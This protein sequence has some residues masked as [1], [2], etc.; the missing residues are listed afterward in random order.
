MQPDLGFA[1]F[2]ETLAQVDDWVVEQATAPGTLLQLALVAGALVV[3]LALAPVLRRRIGG[4]AEQR[5]SAA[6]PA[7]PRLFALLRE[8]VLPALWVAFVW[9]AVVAVRDGGWPVE[10]VSGALSLL[11]A[12]IVIRVA[13]LAIRS[14]PLARMLAVLVWG[15][16]ALEIVDLLDPAAAMLDNLGFSLGTVRVSALGIVKAVGVLAVLLWLAA[17]AARL[18]E[19]LV[20]RVDGLTPAVRVLLSRAAKVGMVALAVLMALSALGVDLTAF[21]F[22]TGAIG[23]GIGLGLQRIVANV[24]AGVIILLDRSI[25]PGDVI[26]I[27]ETYGWIESVSARYTAVRTRDG[28]EHLIPNEELITQ[29]VEN[30]SHTDQLLRLR[31]P[32]GISYKSD[33]R[34]A[35]AIC[36]EAARVSPRVLDEPPPVCLLRGFGDSSVKLEL[37]MWIADPQDGQA[38]VTSEVLLK[39]WDEFHGQG[40]EIPFPQRDLH[41][42]T[43]AVLSVDIAG[44]QA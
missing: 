15:V 9:L 17:L 36:L 10:I 16:V 20:Q 44:R 4:P 2:G 21:A 40:I 22:L 26:A 25:K 30:W 39:I 37:R 19:Q 13:A 38:N 23:I 7:A 12:W 31:V 41:L 14:R 27:G 6:W 35:M 5:L 11:V 33:L 18:V 29:R 3:A 34:R 32:V 1:D 42:K 24:I 28:T 43:P 8:L